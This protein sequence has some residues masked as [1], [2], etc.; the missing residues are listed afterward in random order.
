MNKTIKIF[1]CVIIL[2]ISLIFFQVKFTGNAITSSPLSV[3]IVYPSSGQEVFGTAVVISANTTSISEITEVQFFVDGKEYEAPGTRSFYSI[4]FDATAYSNSSHTIL[5]RVRDTQGNTAEDSITINVNN[6]RMSEAQIIASKFSKDPNKPI[7]KEGHTLISLSRWGWGI[8]WEATFESAKN[9]GYALELGSARLATTSVEGDWNF[10]YMRNVMDISASNP[11]KYPL[12]T[13]LSRSLLK[14]TPTL[15]N[16]DASAFTKYENGSY[17]TR[18]GTLIISPEAPNSVFEKIAEHRT[19]FL[20]DLQKRVPIAIVLN[21]GEDLLGVTGWMGRYWKYDPKI[22]AAKGD[23]SWPEYVAKNKGRQEG[24][25]AKAVQDALPS[26]EAY[27]FYSA[28]GSFSSNWGWGYDALKDSS[29]FPSDSN[30]LWHGNSGLTGADDMLTKVTY[31]YGIESSYNHNFSYNW[32]SAGW[33]DLERFAP[34]DRY[35]GFLKAYYTTGMIG[36]ISYASY[37]IN[38]EEYPPWLEQMIILS[39]VHAEFSH[40]E[41]FVR[42]SYLLPGPN[43]HVATGGLPTNGFPAFEFPTGDDGSRV[44]VRKKNN[45]QEWLITAWSSL[46]QTR[47]VSVNIPELGEITIASR[48]EGSI[49]FAKIEGGNK[50]ITWIDPDFTVPSRGNCVYSEFISGSPTLSGTQCEDGYKCT[51]DSTC[52]GKGSCSLGK[53]QDSLCPNLKNCGVSLCN[54]LHPQAD[55]DGCFYSNCPREPILKYNFE[56][57]QE[58][59]VVDARGRFNVSGNLPPLIAQGKMGKAIN[60]SGKGDLL[61]VQDSEKSDLNILGDEITISAWIYPT[62]NKDKSTIVSKKGNYYLQRDFDGR[63]IA[64]LP[65]TVNEAKSYSIGSAPLNQWT[66]VAYSYNGEKLT[67]YINGKA[68]GSYSKQGRLEPT[69]YPERPLRIGGD[70]TTGNDFFS[71][72]IDNLEIY[73]TS[74]S[75]VEM[76]NLYA[77]YPVLNYLEPTKED[78]KYMTENSFIVNLS[79]YSPEKLASVKLYLSK[80]EDLLDTQEIVFDEKPFSKNVSFEFKNLGDGIYSYEAVA[81]NILGESAYSDKR[82]LVIDNQMPTIDFDEE[83]SSNS[84]SIN[85]KLESSDVAEHSTFLDWERSLLAWYRFDERKNSSLIYDNSTWKNDAEINDISLGEGKYGKSG[86]FNGETSSMDLGTSEIFNF[87]DKSFTISM[88]IKGGNESFQLNHF[89][90]TGWSTSHNPQ[91]GFL[92]LNNNREHYFIMTGPNGAVNLQITCG[93]FEEDW[94]QLVVIADKQGNVSCYKNKILQDTKTYPVGEIQGEGEKEFHIGAKK[95]SMGYTRFEGELDDFMI[96]TRALSSSEINS[97]YNSQLSPYENIFNNLQNSEYSL[98][99]YVQDP[100]GNSQKTSLIN[101]GLNSYYGGSSSKW[102]KKIDFVFDT[103]VGD[104]PSLIESVI[105]VSEEKGRVLSSIKELTKYPEKLK[106]YLTIFVISLVTFFI[107]I[108]F[109]Y[110]IKKIIKRHIEF[111]KFD[112]AEKEEDEILE[113][114]MDNSK[115]I[116]KGLEKQ[117]FDFS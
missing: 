54:P 53:K 93:A 44:L 74:F 63:I 76:Y 114:L 26:R 92:K 40:L 110:K 36:G 61:L 96:W 109:F 11:E 95:A 70:N 47:N 83:M 14:D 24:I 72:Q 71:G 12:S 19:S 48:P 31:S 1:L 21:G 85:A 90:H 78:W 3:K 13:L 68:S 7:F 41:D 57:S 113:S 20:K 16:T 10:E 102:K 35:M 79:L 52:D 37:E 106:Q 30:Y 43:M 89:V 50:K 25:I 108:L 67:F 91:L 60:F 6:A 23:Q 33:N 117:D 56:N 45:A 22:M 42:N 87:Q 69:I 17:A 103:L 27:I 51:I 9:W 107:L 15:E 59:K 81:D 58:G 77:D 101:F 94:T 29:D 104:K 86:I 115:Q 34:S 66:H 38:E 84:T 82:T 64:Y 112:P 73:S 28:P 97:L 88:W 39:Q 111:A 18:G 75:D 99:A 4:P 105:G 100:F 46:G 65:G 8:P 49:Y 80:N 32:V 116:Q 55:S 62:E 5:V 2:V 98:Q